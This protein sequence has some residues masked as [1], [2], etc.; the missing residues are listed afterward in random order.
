MNL[1]INS[2]TLDNI[3]LNQYQWGVQRLVIA[4]GVTA[5]TNVDVVYNCQQTESVH[6]L[7]DTY[8]AVD[9]TLDDVSVQEVP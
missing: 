2:G 3:G 7:F 5:S 4:G 6:I 8:N 9:F 1:T